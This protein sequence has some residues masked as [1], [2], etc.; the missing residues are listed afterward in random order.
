MSIDSV[1][2]GV[3]TADV[4][5][6]VTITGSNFVEDP[7]TTT[8]L[9]DGVSTTPSSITETQIVVNRQSGCRCP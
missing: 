8:V 1:S 4:A 7:Y 3:L 2:P 9:V 6:D 5:T